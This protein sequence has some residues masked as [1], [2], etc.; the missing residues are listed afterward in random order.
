MDLTK[1]S[2]TESFLPD[3]CG[4]RA[5]FVVVMVSELLVFVLVVAD[6]GLTLAALP[7]LALLS[8]YVQL[9]TLSAA[10]ILCL[11][12]PHLG[13]LPPARGAAFGYLL[14]LC[15]VCEAA[16]WALSPV[17]G[18]LSLI[19]LSHPQFFGR[20][21]VV[22][23]IVSALILR[24]FHVQ[25]RWERQVAAEARARLCALQARIRP[26]FL[27]NCM[28]SIASLTRSN[29]A[30]AEQAVENL[31]DLFR[32]SLKEGS[33]LVTVAEECELASRYLDIEAL[34]LGDRLRLSWDVTAL[35]RDAV[36]PQFTLQ[37]LLENAVLRGIE[38]LPA[39]GAISIVGRR[40]RSGCLALAVHN[41]RDATFTRTEG[42]Q[43]AQENVRQRL[44]A[45]FG[46]RGRLTLEETPTSYT[47]TV[48]FPAMSREALG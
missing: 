13:R 25:H 4:T 31:A 8:L 46:S 24:F 44:E 28:N 1:R 5:L 23:A 38:P 9:L 16:W 11:A 37:P 26:H 12:R 7:D 18:E 39:G 3:L 10:A 2:Q 14:V 19:E 27:F 35:P 41:P 17:P 42:H 30:A 47:V 43:L 40:D 15:L 21:L 36:L 29:P 20:T 6:S 45:C 22:G 33:G 48:Q 34:R 32:A